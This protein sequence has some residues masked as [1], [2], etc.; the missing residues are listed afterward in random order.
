MANKVFGLDFTNEPDPTGGMTISVH[1][2]TVLRD[3]ELQNLHKALTQ[4]TDA[5][6]GTVE[7]AT[8]AEGI[9]GT[10]TT[11]VITPAV[12][13]AILS[14]V[15][16]VSENQLINGGFT[17]A[18]RQTPGTLT[19]IATDTYSAD[20]WRISRENAELQYQRNDALAESG[21]TS[22]YYGLYKKITNAGK[23]MVYQ[24]IEGMNSVPLRGK[25]VVFQAKMKASSTKNIRMAVLELQNAGTLDTIPG[26]FVTAWG[27]DSTDPTLGT[28]VA[29]ITAAQTKSVTTSW[30]SFSVS[31]TVPSNSKNLIVAI[32]SDADFAAND[33]LSIAEAGLF[34]GSTIQQWVMRPF[35]GEL[36]LCQRYYWKTFN[37]ETGPA[38]NAG[39]SVGEHRYPAPVAGAATQRSTKLWFPTVM[40]TT[41]T[42]VT[43]NPS[44]ANAQMR[45]VNVPGD[46]SGT[47][48]TPKENGL[49]LSATGHAS[50][51]VGNALAVHITAE[52]EL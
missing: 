9:T 8:S 7:L 30:Q 42:I 12:L 20:R 6:A 24:I 25:T 21:L 36:A 14:A 34:P 50:T 45:D 46:C 4:A 22:L 52:A 16:N 41:P 3:I 19:T 5:Q 11:R 15:G 26:T 23:F 17:F 32:W 37:I 39:L 48:T 1:N 31:V 10:D 28:N 13:A 38:Q 18:Q 33:T 47:A 49:T 27:A 35:A 51:S 29:I 43:Y 40:R 2:G 44:A